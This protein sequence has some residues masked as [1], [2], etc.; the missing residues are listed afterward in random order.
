[1]LYL[2]LTCM[3]ALFLLWSLALDSCNDK[4]NLR[5]PFP[6]L[7]RAVQSAPSPL[8]MENGDRVLRRQG[9]TLPRCFLLEPAEPCVVE[10]VS[11]CGGHCA[12]AFLLPSSH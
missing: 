4:L 7:A 12:L 3:C 8:C 9:L 10:P 11:A 2:L 5:D 1:M 6:P